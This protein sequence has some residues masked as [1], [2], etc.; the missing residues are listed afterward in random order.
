LDNLFYRYLKLIQGYL[1]FY[2]ISL[3]QLIIDI[4]N[5][6]RIQFLYYIIFKFHTSIYT[7]VKKIF[8][9]EMLGPKS[10]VE[11]L[12]YEERL[13]TVLGKENFSLALDLLN[14]A[15]VVG[16]LSIEAMSML[17][18]SNTGKKDNQKLLREIMDIL[19]HDGYLKE[20]KK[21]YVFV[22]PLLKKWWQGR[23]KAYY[24]PSGERS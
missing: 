15:A 10:Q 18:A 16:V 9:K 3:H 24:I 21:G 13:N 11:L 1:R 20:T 22:A 2:K 12:S 19:I 4:L 6:I 14:E 23:Y 8:K 17:A 5:P 7:D